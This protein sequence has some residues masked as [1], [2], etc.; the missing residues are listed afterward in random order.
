MT[1]SALK[2]RVGG[3]YGINVEVLGAGKTLTPGVDKIYQYLDPNGAVRLI[4]IPAAGAQAGDRFVIRNTGLFSASSYLSLPKDRVYAGKICG[5]VF[6][7]TDW[8]AEKIGT[9][10][11]GNLPRNL[12]IGIYSK[13]YTYGTAL[14]YSAEAYSRGVAVGFSSS[15]HTDGVAIGNAAKGYSYGIAIGYETDT[16]AKRYSIALGFF[17]ECERVGETS[18]NIDGNVVQKNNVVQGRWSKTTTDATPV[19][20]FCAG[21]STSRFT[22]RASSALAFRMTIVARDN[23][24]GHV[25]MWT[26]ADG[27]IKRDDAD[28]TVIVTCTV[29][30]VADESTD[31]A[32]AVTADDVNES[33]KIEVTGDPANPTQFAAVMEAVETHF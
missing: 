12:A 6:D 23:V 27:L 31:W 10:E 8:V 33:L 16:H 20:M 32:V 19:E 3:L 1:D 21:Y 7:G 15:S 29:V 25:A 22:I 18:T 9:G 5:L 4:T 2:P 17:S 11:D 14:G 28:N 26:V 30:E 24:A 13:G